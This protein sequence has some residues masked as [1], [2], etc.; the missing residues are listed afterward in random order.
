MADIL[1]SPVQWEQLD[2]N[3][4]PV[5]MRLSATVVSV[6]HEGSPNS[7]KGVVVTYLRDGRL[8]KLRA[9]CAILCG[10][11]HAN[12]HIC[13]D[14]SPEYREAMNS[15]HHAPMLT[16]NIAVRNWKFL[17]RLG[18]A[19]ARWFEG[20]GWWISLRR[21]LEIPGQPILHS[22][23]GLLCMAFEADGELLNDF[24]FHASSPSEI[25]IFIR[26]LNSASIS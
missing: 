25:C 24:C 4:E 23:L 8:F 1:N 18:I 14:V 15:F 22:R 5:K 17:E 13:K 9:K 7:A 16:V 6:F 21:N 20:F 11:Q 26:V 2:R 10:Q 19:S 12:R 3:G